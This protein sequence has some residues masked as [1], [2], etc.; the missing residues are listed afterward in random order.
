MPSPAALA[1]DLV[2]VVDTTGSMR[3]VLDYVK[4]VVLTMHEDLIDVAG[5]RGYR[6]L[7]VR[8]RLVAFRDL[9][10]DRHPPLVVTP[11]LTFP[12]DL[13]EFEGAV[14]GLEP[15]GG[16]D[17]PESSLDALSIALASPWTARAGERRHVVVLHTDA[18]AHRPSADQRATSLGA[19]SDLPG[20]SAQWMAL[21][22]ESKRMFICAPDCNPW[23]DVLD[24]WRWDNVVHLVSKAGHGMTDSQLELVLEWLVGAEV[25]AW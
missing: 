11:M 24:T 18:S 20:L 21:D 10:D 25:D 14:N 5:L 13:S 9:A 6:D 22:P 15:V 3:L 16:R 4:S 23:L 2:H 17:D 12:D 19:V 1:I 8:V 7:A